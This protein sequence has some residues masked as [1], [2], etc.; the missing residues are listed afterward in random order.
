MYDLERGALNIMTETIC[1]QILCS[2]MASS[3]KLIFV[4]IHKHTKT[5][6]YMFCAKIACTTTTRDRQKVNVCGVLAGFFEGWAYAKTYKNIY[7]LHVF[8]E[9]LQSELELHVVQMT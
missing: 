6:F 4:H 9:K 1:E 2:G 7:V 8:Y 5:S 3:D